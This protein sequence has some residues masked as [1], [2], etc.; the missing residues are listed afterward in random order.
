MVAGVGL[1]GFGWSVG[2]SAA[3]CWGS[4]PGLSVCEGADFDQVV[5]EDSVSDPDPCSFEGVDAAAVPAVAAFQGADP[6]FAAGAPFHVSSEG[7]S[8]F[9]GLSGFAGS[10]LAGDDDVA[11]TEVVEGVVDG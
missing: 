4:L 10:P 8:V 6:C 2:P 7:S 3:G 11:H 9:G 5:G 1:A